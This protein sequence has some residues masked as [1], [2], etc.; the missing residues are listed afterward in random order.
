MRRVNPMSQPDPIRLLSAIQRNFDEIS[1]ALLKITAHDQLCRTEISYCGPSFLLIAMDA[2]VNDAFA[3]AIRVLD[4]H[5]DAASFWYI[6]KCEEKAVR[7]AA[8]SAGVDIQ[9]LEELSEKL[10]MVRTK[11][12]FH[13]DREAVVDPEAAWKEAN[14]AGSTLTTQL[15]GLADTLARTKQALIGG[16]LSRITPYDGSDVPKIISAYEQCY[17]P[18][19]GVPP[20]T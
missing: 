17:G 15:K 8:K 7:K 16:E 6:L 9:Q 1:D 10:R 5:K 11:T 20:S 2:L 19:H 13:I 3:H 4:K 18:I 14:L 12:H